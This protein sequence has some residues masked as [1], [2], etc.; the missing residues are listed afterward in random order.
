[1]DSNVKKGMMENSES[2]LCETKMDENHGQLSYEESFYTTTED[3]SKVLDHSKPTLRLQDYT[4]PILNDCNCNTMG[5]IDIQDGEPISINQPEKFFSSRPWTE[6]NLDEIEDE[7]KRWAEGNS[8]L[9]IPPVV[10][11]VSSLILKQI[12]G[13]LGKKLL[14]SLFEKLFPTPSP[15]TILEILEAVEELL[16][17]RLSPGSSAPGYVRIRGVTTKYR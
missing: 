8:F 10:G 1:M 16:N 7:W 9:Y 4:N 3:S 6:K 15:V 13:A 5:D 14:N 11:T 2:N 12:A 17:Q